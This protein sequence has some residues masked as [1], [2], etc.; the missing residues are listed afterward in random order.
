VLLQV[1]DG[2]FVRVQ[3]AERGTLDC[4]PANLVDVVV[5]PSA[6]NAG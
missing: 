1:R 3:P 4:D 5:D 6:V 2:A